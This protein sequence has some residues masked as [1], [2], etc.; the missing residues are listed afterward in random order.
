MNNLQAYV[1]LTTA[2]ANTIVIGG[3]LIACNSFLKNPVN[4]E[5]YYFKKGINILTSAPANFNSNTQ[6]TSFKQ[7]F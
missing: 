1:E 2:I 6:N 3:F 4:V 5:K 7:R